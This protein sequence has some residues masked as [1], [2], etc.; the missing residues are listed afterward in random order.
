MPYIHRTYCLTYDVTDD[1][2]IPLKDINELR[3]NAIDKLNEIR[4]YKTD[5]KKSNYYID[6]PDYSSER[7]LTCLV[8]SVDKYKNLDRKYDMVFLCIKNKSRFFIVSWNF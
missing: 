3:R 6:V 1:I 2:F 8:D 7:L 4:L 5:F